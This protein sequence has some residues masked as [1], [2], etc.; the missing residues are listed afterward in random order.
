MMQSIT[1]MQIVNGGQT[2]ASLFMTKRLIKQKKVDL[3][4]VHI[5]VKL[6]VIDPD[7]VDEVVPDFEMLTLRTNNT[8]TSSPIIHTTEESKISRRLLP[9][10]RWK[11]C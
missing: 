6:S 4:K 5:Q 7:K 2:T 9:F 8:P 3:S 11:P 1:N 10:N